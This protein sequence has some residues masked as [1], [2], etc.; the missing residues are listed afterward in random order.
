MDID[1]IAEVHRKIEDVLL[2]DWDPIGVAGVPEAQDEYRGYVRRVYDVAVSNRSAKAISKLL[3][4]FERDSMGLHARKPDE[5]DSVANKILE[6][7]A[8]CK[9]LP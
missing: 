9:A 7:V 4:S 1:F 3:V 2:N 6:L 5:L 8:N